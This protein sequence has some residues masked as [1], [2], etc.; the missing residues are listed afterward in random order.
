MEHVTKL[1]LESKFQNKGNKQRKKN[2]ENL[3]VYKAATCSKNKIHV[4]KYYAEKDI[5]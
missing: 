5:N 3:A 4:S 1:L 2:A